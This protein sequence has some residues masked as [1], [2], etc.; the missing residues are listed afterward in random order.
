MTAVR[1]RGFGDLCNRPVTPFVV[2][3][4]NLRSIIRN[5][6][7]LDGWTDDPWGWTRERIGTVH[8][9]QGREAE[10][11]I[12]VLGAPSSH[13]SGAHGLGWRSTEP[14]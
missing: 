9:V 7:V 2:V 10:A 8:T 11:V 3:Q 12:F 13:Q 5:S 4:D 14:P 6:G 1:F